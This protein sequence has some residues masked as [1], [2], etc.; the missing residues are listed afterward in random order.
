MWSFE[1]PRKRFS[2]KDVSEKYDVL[3]SEAKLYCDC[4]CIK[5]F[6]ELKSFSRS[7]N[8]MLELLQ[9]FESLH[10]HDAA[11]KLSSILIHLTENK[12][13]INVKISIYFLS[14]VA[15]K[16]YQSQYRSKYS[17]RFTQRF[18][19]SKNFEFSAISNIRSLE[20]FCWSRGS[21]I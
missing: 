11:R 19:E 4:K 6:A 15:F 9:R 17:I 18:I 1:R 5:Y 16:T 20:L 14:S 12:I 21:S 13:P 10:V 2:N 8:D 3:C 7:K